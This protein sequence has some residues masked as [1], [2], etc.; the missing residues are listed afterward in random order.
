MDLEAA[1]Y[2]LAD[3][4]LNALEAGFPQDRVR[5]WFCAARS[6]V[7]PDNWRETFLTVAETLKMPDAD[8]LPIE[9]FLFKND[10]PYVKKVMETKAL[11]VKKLEERQ[12][13]SKDTKKSLKWKSDHWK[14]RRMLN[15]PG[16][17]MERTCSLE[18]ALIATGLGRRERDL[19]HIVNEGVKRSSPL[20]ELKHS[21]E[22]VV[23]HA[24]AKHKTSKASTS[25]L[26]L[27]SKILALPPAVPSARLLVGLEA[28]SL[29]GVPP[30]YHNMSGG[31]L[32]DN[33]YMSLA[34]NAFNGG[35]CGLVLL[36]AF[37]TL[38]FLS[39]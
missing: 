27:S 33:D 4:L 39:S 5:A 34:G 2:Q 29:Q 26:L 9:S 13:G 10:H 12:L 14:M 16:A 21:A 1:G 38:R 8:L 20:I 28:F 37:A 24:A 11:R 3:L 35:C 15:L 17:P 18:L 22:R 23:L 6:D 25:C 32:S 30:C 31:L 36:T 19:L 7:C